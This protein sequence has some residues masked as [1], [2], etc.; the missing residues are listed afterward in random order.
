MHKWHDV[1]RF[2]FLATLVGRVLNNA[3][4]SSCGAI[5]NKACLD[6][7][8]GKETRFVSTMTNFWSL[9]IWMF[10]AWILESRTWFSAGFFLDIAV[11]APVR[12]G[13]GSFPHR[14]TWHRLNTL[15]T[16]S[17]VI[18]FWIVCKSIYVHTPSVHVLVAKT[19]NKVQVSCNLREEMLITWTETRTLDQYPTT[20]LER[21]N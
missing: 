1:V 5:R 12:R 6:A 7:Y 21:T 14:M 16:I 9:I 13:L 8:I 2:T 15:A 20:Y 11:Q 10:M 19:E 18:T 3:A 17:T 4:H